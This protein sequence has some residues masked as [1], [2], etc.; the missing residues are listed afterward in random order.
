MDMYYESKTAVL[1][2]IS[3]LEYTKSTV[4]IYNRCLDAFGLYLNENNIAYSSEIASAWVEKQ[5]EKIGASSWCL[6][7]ASIFKLDQHYNTG[8]IQG[9]YS[10]SRKTMWGLLSSDYRMTVDGLLSGLNRST[11]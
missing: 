2:Y 6:Y 3:S 1:N 8:L 4:D 9:C 5:K 11:D 10:D 7:R